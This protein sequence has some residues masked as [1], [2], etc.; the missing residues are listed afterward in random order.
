ML[1]QPVSAVHCTSF[2]FN[3]RHCRTPTMT[4]TW[5]AGKR[6]HLS[7]Y[8]W[9]L[10]NVSEQLILIRSQL[11]RRRRQAL[12]PPSLRLSQTAQRARV[13]RHE[14]GSSSKAPKIDRKA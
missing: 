13:M 6:H 1:T 12:H 14:I 4:S 2:M 10:C 3:D 7:Y 8:I 9:S 11:T 5:M